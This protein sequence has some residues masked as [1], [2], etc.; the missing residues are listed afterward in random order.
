MYANPPTSPRSLEEDQ[1]LVLFD[2]L[3]LFTRLSTNLAIQVACQ[4][5]Q[6][7]SSLPDRTSLTPSEIVS[8]LELCLNATY[9]AFR[10]TYYQDTTPP[11]A[12]VTIPYVKNTS[13]SIRRILAPLGIRT[14]FQPTN[15]LRQV[16]V[17]PKDPVPKENRSG[18]I[19][20]IP[21]SRCSQTYIGQ[22]GR[23]LGQRLKEHQRAVRNRNTSTSALV[24]HVCSTG[25]SVDWN[26]AQICD[27]CPHTSKQYLLESWMIQK[28]PSTLNRELGP[29]LPVYNRLF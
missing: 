12:Y 4:R 15:T 18:V 13:E 3:S 28:Q 25:H 22:T 2:V 10:N 7:V 5:L 11:N 24:D 19:Y 29:L 20:Q 9:F 8:L 14:S 16:L 6:D 21:C 17:R 1:V 23:I 26:K 27:S